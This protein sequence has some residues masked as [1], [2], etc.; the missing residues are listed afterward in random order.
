MFPHELSSLMFYLFACS[1]SIILAHGVSKSVKRR[2][3]EE[4][5]SAHTFQFK[6][7]SSRI[8]H[9]FPEQPF[10]SRLLWQKSLSLVA[11]YG[12]IKP[13]CC[14]CCANKNKTKRYTRARSGRLALASIIKSERWIDESSDRLL[15]CRVTRIPIK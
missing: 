10:F 2:D 14:W 9:V 13:E 6:W 7:E 11:F 4:R 1:F 15:G 3:N 8:K 12:Q 5:S